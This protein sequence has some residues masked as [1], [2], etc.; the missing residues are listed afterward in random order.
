MAAPQIEGIAKLCYGSSAEIKEFRPM[1]AKVAESGQ[2]TNQSTP[3]ALAAFNLPFAS[4]RR[5]TPAIRAAK[6]A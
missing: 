5:W 2:F 4:R 6:D 1:R 3:P